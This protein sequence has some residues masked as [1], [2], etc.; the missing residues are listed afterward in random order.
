MVD[1]FF[2]ID[3]QEERCC[4]FLSLGREGSIC[5][6]KRFEQQVLFCT[7]FL[8]TFFVCLFTSL[9][10]TGTTKKDNAYEYHHC[11]SASQSSEW[12]WY[13]Q[14]Y[15]YIYRS[16]VFLASSFIDLFVLFLFTFCNMNYRRKVNSW[17]FFVS[18]NSDQKIGF[19]LFK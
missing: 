9:F 1:Y 13:A 4:L 17:F 19:L 18:F 6:T 8:F 10:K 11:I 16:N 15:M 5:I 12:F 2:L 3:W 7:F 14:I